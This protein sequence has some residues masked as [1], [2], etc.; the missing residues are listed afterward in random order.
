MKNITIKDVAREANVSVTLVSRVMNAP[1]DK[2]GEP[3]CSVNRNTAAKILAV[4]KRMGYRPNAAAANLRKRTK[5]RIGVILPDISHPFFAEMAR[6]FETIARNEG[7]TVLLGSSMDKAENIENLA[8]TFMVDNADGII[9]IPGPDCESV[10]E[11][12][13]S[14]RIPLVLAVR[15][16]LN[17]S[18]VGRVLPDN[19]KATEMALGHLLASGSGKIDMIS[20]ALRVSTV[21]E[22][23][24]MFSEY[25]KTLGIP[26]RIIH[27][28]G[29]NLDE[30]IGFILEEV[31]RHGTDAIYCPNESI[32]LSIIKVCREKGIRIL[33]STA[34]LGY[35]GGDHFDIV[36][37]TISQI[38]FSRREVAE[39]AFNIIQEMV[40]NGASGIQ[41]V[42]VKPRLIE[43]ASTACKSADNQEAAPDSPLDHIEKAIREMQL[44][45]GYIKKEA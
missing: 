4:V 28:N 35:D 40:N 12:I 14:Q 1:L 10:V 8:M 17:V 44:A 27:C 25:L 41:T 21:I 24:R 16:V 5:K 26:Y 11:K 19:K 9:L 15:D 45:R 33:E 42:Y 36:T 34:L 29:D 20:P 6:E 31:E 37:P 23:E 18:D 13:V 7:Y 22:R 32:P 2:N 30:S 3:Q 43:G 38:S 39:E